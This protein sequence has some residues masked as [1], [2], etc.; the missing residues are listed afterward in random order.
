MRIVYFKGWG[1][2]FDESIFNILNKFG[3]DVFMPDFDY[4]N[5]AN[6]INAYINEIYNNRKDTIIIGKSLGAYMSYH[7]SNVVCMP[8]LLFNPTFFFKSGGELKPSGSSSGNEYRDKQ[9]IFTMKDDEID[10]K[11]TFK[12]LKELKYDDQNIKTYDDLNQ[13]PLDVFENEF[14]SFREKYKNFNASSNTPDL[15]EKLERS[16]YH[17]KKL[18]SSTRAT[19]TSSGGGI[20]TGS[21][22][23]D[24]WAT[25]VQKIKFTTSSVESLDQDV[26]W[27]SGPTAADQL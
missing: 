13:I 14:S 24:D 11:R 10:M 26:W 1:E 8:S 15:I 16:I 4:Q 12:Y 2:Q 6:L 25:P 27:N 5:S 3:D 18:K 9:F 17:E 22:A 23:S 20:S 19:L 21:F 7:I